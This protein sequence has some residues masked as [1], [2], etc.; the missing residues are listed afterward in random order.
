MQQHNCP[1]GKE[2]A[3]IQNWT[4]LEV[5]DGW[6][7]PQA[8][9]CVVREAHFKVGIRFCTFIWGFAWSD[10]TAAI[11]QMSCTAW[12]CLTQMHKPST[13]IHNVCNQNKKKK[14]HSQKQGGHDCSRLAMLSKEDNHW[15]EALHHEQHL[16]LQ[17]LN[18]FSLLAAESNG[19]NLGCV[20]K[21]IGL[22][23]QLHYQ[24]PRFPA[25][26]QKFTEFKIYCR[27]RSLAWNFEELR[28][29]RKFPWKMGRLSLAFELFPSVHEYYNL[30][31]LVR[32][33]KGCNLVFL[34]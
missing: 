11:P 30:I 25:N 23:F 21:A 14:R 3:K 18:H 32:I 28:Y 29:F 31:L 13:L 10:G 16:V 7:V 27:I 34:D 4:S 9:F 20:L 17:P 5:T 12:S 15:T 22:P 33:K 6:A 26:P 2:N 8:G 24:D 19:S 1:R